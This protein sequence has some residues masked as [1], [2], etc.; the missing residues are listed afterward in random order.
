MEWWVVLLIVLFGGP[1]IWGMLDS[2]FSHRR[3]MAELKY[4]RSDNEA[5]LIEDK[6]ELQETVRSLNDRLAAL[7]TIATDPA[8][9]TADEIERLR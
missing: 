3:E 5:Q 2:F 4:G 1:S 8:R 6:A 9:R 7:E